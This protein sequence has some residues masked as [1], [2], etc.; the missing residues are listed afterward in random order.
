M[1]TPAPQ[2]LQMPRLPL[3]APPTPISSSQLQAHYIHFLPPPRPSFPAKG[4]G[5]LVFLPPT[6]LFPTV[7]RNGKPQPHRA[8]GDWTGMPTLPSSLCA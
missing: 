3:T 1:E 2:P 7:I 4:V 5:I 6:L 8:V